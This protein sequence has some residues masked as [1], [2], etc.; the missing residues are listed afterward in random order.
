ME[1][2]P[3][4]VNKQ[5]VTFQNPA[6][7]APSKLSSC[8]FLGWALRSSVL[9]DTAPGATWIEFSLL[10]S[11][12]LERLAQDSELLGLAGLDYERLDPPGLGS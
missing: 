11:P 3:C 9:L 8:G 10:G 6:W 12:G 7:V 1:R 5:W 4:A 2:N